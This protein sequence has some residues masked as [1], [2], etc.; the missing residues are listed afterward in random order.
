MSICSF[1][2]EDWVKLGKYVKLS[3]GKKGDKMVKRK[4]KIVKIVNIQSRKEK[5]DKDGD[6]S[7][8]QRRI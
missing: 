3:R 6:I 7:K 2:G 5:G 4:L 1:Q 8:Y